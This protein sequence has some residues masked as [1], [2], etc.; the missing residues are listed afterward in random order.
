MRDD[1]WKPAADAAMD[2]YADGGNAAAFA[3]VYTLL[4]PIRPAGCHEPNGL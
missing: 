2:R 1:S 3:E 4:A